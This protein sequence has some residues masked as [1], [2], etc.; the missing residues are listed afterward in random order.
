MPIF[1]TDLEH[2]LTE[3]MLEDERKLIANM[4]RDLL[5]TFKAPLNEDDQKLVR[6][7]FEMAAEAHKIQRRKDGTPYITHPIAVARIC[8]EE[9]GLGPTAAACALLHDVVED[10]DFTL[11]D[12]RE[13]FPDKVQ[14][15]REKGDKKPKIAS[16]VANIVDG[17]TKL[18]SLHEHEYAQ[19]ENIRRVLE[20]ML[21]DVRVILI[22]M[23]D[24]LH[25]LRTIGAMKPDKQLKIAAETDGIYT[26][27][28]HQL[29]LYKVKTEFQDACL[30]I[31][32]RPAYD[33]IA[34]KLAQT[35]VVREA[36]IQN[37]SEPIKK[38][39]E[40]YGLTANVYGRPK[41][42]HSI[43]EKMTKKK[44][45]FENIYDLFA[46][47]IVLDVADVKQE[48]MQCWQ[49]YA[50]VTDCYKPI[51]ERQKDWL[52][53]PKTNGYESL[54]ISVIGPDARFV[55]VQ[56]RST[57]MDEIAEGGFAAHWKYKGVQGLGAK[58]QIFDKWL[59]ELREILKDQS[60]PVEFIADLQAAIFVEDTV[61]V[62]TPKGDL[63]VLPKGATA[64][65]FAFSIHSDVG[66]TCQ[67]VKV[68]GVL[69]NFNYKVQTG[70]QIEIITNK[71][72]KPTDD[73]LLYVVT[74]KARTR[75]KA[76]LNEEKRK[77]AE[78]G[79]EILARKLNNMH[80]V[81]AEE[82]IDYLAK[83][84]HF[85]NR[86]EFLC[87]IALNKF[88]F[89][90]LKQFRP[91]GRLL[92][93]P[94]PEPKG[95]NVEA[96]TEVSQTSPLTRRQKKF[97]KAKSQAVIINDEPGVYYSYEFANCCTPQPGDAI[98]AYLNANKAALIHSATCKNAKYL[99]SNYAFRFLKAEWGNVVRD[100]Y[101]TELVISGRDIGRGVI[102][103]ISE[104]IERLGINMQS[105]SMSGEEGLFQ[106]NVILEVSTQ[107]HLNLA[108]S[109]LKGFE[110]VTDVEEHRLEG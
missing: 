97:A 67:I 24:R 83:C 27:L 104:C 9:I 47:R 20:A 101:A 14:P 40:E 77:L 34:K 79:K 110:Y 43:F 46:I 39:L 66:C 73:W 85:P 29:G 82:N 64:L 90:L 11:D 19:A 87:A 32:N 78:Q 106:G 17:L 80:K 13:R 81:G 15:E 71:N 51:P 86:L 91:D 54:H 41:S 55:E 2:P 52:S 5:R 76:A 102:R 107:E 7:A 62:F 6:E 65:D 3:E 58:A 100:R 37:F 70:E 16:R 33:D 75:I 63:K 103:E 99:L 50:I 108:I 95:D 1:T 96:P 105:F 72:Q 25:N 57:R 42:I 23:A 26:P 8:V 59:A 84:L 60:N 30:K 4:Y 94:E 18:D 10:T 35:K 36:Y 98:F 48:K 68:D 74:S 22:K 28:A 53:N 93:L 56:I 21:T 49:A 38:E 69:Q 89:A 61:Q 31:T 109:A 44:V 92:V 12:I 88:N 45:E